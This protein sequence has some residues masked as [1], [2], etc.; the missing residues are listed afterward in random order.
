MVQL[1]EKVSDLMLES[2][3]IDCTIH[4]LRRGTPQDYMA[5][6]TTMGLS[7]TKH[8]QRSASKKLTNPSVVLNVP[9]EFP[10]NMVDNP[11]ILVGS[12]VYD[13]ALRSL[14]VGASGCSSIGQSWFQGKCILRGG[15]LALEFTPQRGPPDS[16]VMHP[17]VIMQS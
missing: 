5:S 17:K 9:G 11:A 1:S 3:R 7:Q 4:A 6:I 10:V 13:W 8:P 15:T 12:G 16:I 2:P 14:R